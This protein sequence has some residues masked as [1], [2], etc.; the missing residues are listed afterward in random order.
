MRPT[1]SPPS[2]VVGP[3]T[4][5]EFRPVYDELLPKLYRFFCYRVGDRKL[6]EDLTAMTLEKAWRGRANF[7]PGL[8]EFTNWVMGIARKVNADHH[9][10]NHPRL[11]PDALIQAPVSIEEIAERDAEFARL[12]A[13]LAQ[14][15]R[16]ERD[17]L[18]LKY[19]ADMSNRAIA[20]LTGLTESNVG[21]ILHRAVTKLRAKWETT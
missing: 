16:R 11:A 10:T 19:G 6:A 12:A 15:S 18:A 17:L 13:L 20:E 8:G 14:V 7:N 9:R 21:T 3:N 5:V 1:P 2:L 4:D